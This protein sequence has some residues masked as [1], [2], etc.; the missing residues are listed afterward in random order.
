MR[1][2]YLRFSEAG[3][4]P[5][6]FLQPVDGPQSSAFGLRRVLNGEPR[7]PHSGIDIAAPTGTPIRNPAPGVVTITGDFYFNGKTVFV[8]HGQGLI[9]M[10]CHLS[11]IDVA[12]GDE[13]AR[14]AVLGL[15]GSTG[16]ST[17]PH[18][19]WSVSMNGSRVDPEQVMTLLREQ[20]AD[21]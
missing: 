15:V 2:E 13:V 5:L 18:L 10:V 4:S 11:R 12:E 9:S 19:H 17:G 20:P 7:A 6:P 14:G 16:R 8:D 3:E 21:P 1:A